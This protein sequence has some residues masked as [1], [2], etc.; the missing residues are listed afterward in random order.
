MRSSSAL[1]PCPTALVRRGWLAFVCTAMLLTT[2]AT[3][4]AAGPDDMPDIGGG[5]HEDH[6]LPRTPYV[7]LY[8]GAGLSC[9]F[10]FAV[11]GVGLARRR[12]RRRESNNAQVVTPSERRRNDR[13]KPPV[14]VTLT[15]RPENLD[16]AALRREK[17][18]DV[19]KVEHA[20]EWHT[21]H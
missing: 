5:A 9:L 18:R 6:T 10:F 16:L 7:P 1:Q 21:L 2:T 12:S 13:R 15:P 8:L 20:G 11:A 4:E 17:T 14:R 19:P 3:V